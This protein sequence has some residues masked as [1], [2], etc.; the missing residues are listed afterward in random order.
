M[1]YRE[2]SIRRLGQ[3]LAPNGQNDA[4]NEQGGRRSDIMEFG[5]D[6]IADHNPLEFEV[7]KG[8]ICPLD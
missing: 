6:G 4:Q 8:L 5:G 7:C 2:P 1:H 3:D